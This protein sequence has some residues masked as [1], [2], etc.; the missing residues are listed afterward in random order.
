MRYRPY[1]R[2]EFVGDKKIQKALF[3]ISGL[4]HYEASI[5]GSKI[6]NSFLAP[7]W[8]NYDKNGFVHSYDIT[9]LLQNG[10]NTL[11]ITL[12]NGFL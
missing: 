11:G 6:G 7:G 4:G 5:N 8:T 10:R 1:F 12:G 9:H 2:K 3:F